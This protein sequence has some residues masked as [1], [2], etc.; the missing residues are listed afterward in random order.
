VRSWPDH[1][2]IATAAVPKAAAEEIVALG[3]QAVVA[4]RWM[5]L[6]TWNQVRAAANAAVEFLT[7]DR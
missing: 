6:R 7:A 1:D 3:L 5:R 4:A 2:R